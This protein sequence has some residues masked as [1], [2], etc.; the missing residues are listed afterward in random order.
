MLVF[1]GDLKHCASPTLWEKKLS[2]LSAFFPSPR[3]RT[4]SVELRFSLV[5]ELLCEIY[6]LLFLPFLATGSLVELCKGHSNKKKKKHPIDLFVSSAWDWDRKFV[7]PSQK[8]Q[9]GIDEAICGGNCSLTSKI[10]SHK[11][12]TCW[13]VLR[14]ANLPKVPKDLINKH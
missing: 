12:H 13:I 2:D 9:E 4:L 3:S 11:T 8:W 14:C 10:E 5:S 7:L 1:L 6:K